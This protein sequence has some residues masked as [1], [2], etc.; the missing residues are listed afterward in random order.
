MKNTIIA[1]QALSLLIVS[2]PTWAVSPQN[3][4]SGSFSLKTSKQFTVHITDSVAI[5]DE[6]IVEN[7]TPPLNVNTAF[8]IVTGNINSSIGTVYVSAP[9]SALNSFST[10]NK[11]WL[12][13]KDQ[14]KTSGLA[15]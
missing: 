4:T 13:G 9:L 15:V 7:K 3:S 14:G 1:F 12:I 10:A 8:P 11:S 2:R 6:L 5:T